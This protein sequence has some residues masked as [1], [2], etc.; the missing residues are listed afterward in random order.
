MGMLLKN[1]ITD[2]AEPLSSMANNLATNRAL[3]RLG[4]GT[5]VKDNTFNFTLNIENAEGVQEFFNSSLEKE[6]NKAISNFS[7]GGSSQ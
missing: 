2:D 5:T 6:L 1:Y 7:Y 3:D 4:M